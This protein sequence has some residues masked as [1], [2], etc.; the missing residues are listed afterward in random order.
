MCKKTFPR[1]STCHACQTY[2]V[3]GYVYFTLLEFGWNTL[4]YLIW[5]T[6]QKAMGSRFFG[7][8]LLKTTINLC[9]ET[10]KLKEFEIPLVK[11]D[12]IF[13]GKTSQNFKK[14][15]TGAS[16]LGSSLSTFVTK[17]SCMFPFHILLQIEKRENTAKANGWW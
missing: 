6:K 13:F 4:C 2:S 8:L 16:M 9:H 3:K 12:Q 1:L 5:L 10:D 11:V 15:C 14:Q 17:I 7:Q